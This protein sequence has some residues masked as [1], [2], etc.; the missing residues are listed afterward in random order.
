MQHLE[1]TRHIADRFNKR[2]GEFFPIPEAR[3]TST[4]KILS[5]ADP[6]KKM[7]KSLG[8]KHYI[9]LFEPEEEIQKKIKAAVTDSGNGKSGEMSPGVFNLFQIL[10]A[11]E[12]NGVYETLHNDY[13]KGTLKYADLKAAVSESV[14]NLTHQLKEKRAEL[15]KDKSLLFDVIREMSKRARAMAQETLFEVKE[16][17][18]IKSISYF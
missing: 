6:Q 10:Q 14:V 2:Y 13:K 12:G 3:K 4:P 7:S 11:S 1:L 18:G 9:G 17:V 5:L 15:E 8:E 16:R